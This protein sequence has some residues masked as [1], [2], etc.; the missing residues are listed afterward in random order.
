[1]ATKT[2]NATSVSGKQGWY[3]STSSAIQDS[4]TITIKLPSFTGAEN[5]TISDAKLYI[6]CEAAGASRKKQFA[7]TFKGTNGFSKT[8]TSNGNA[9]NR[10][11][12]LSLNS[13]LK[14]LQEWLASGGTTITS[15]DPQSDQKFGSGPWYSYNYTKITAAKL[16]LTYTY[17]NSSL[18]FNDE[19][20]GIGKNYSL[21][22][23][24]SDET[25]IHDLY[26]RIDESNYSLLNNRTTGTYAI[27]VP[28]AI[29]SNHL[30][31]STSVSGE[32]VL[33]TKKSDETE[34]GT[35]SYPITISADNDNCSPKINSFSFIPPQDNILL[36]D[37]SQLSFIGEAEGSNGSS[38]VSYALSY[39]SSFYETN[40]TGNFTIIAPAG[41]EYI[42]TLTATDTRG[43]STSILS[44]SIYVNAYAI[45][46]I[47]I[48]GFYRCDQYGTRDDVSGT[49]AIISFTKIVSDIK[50]STGENVSNDGTVRVKLNGETY[51][52]A[53]SGS[54]FGKGQLKVD[55][56]YAA[57][58]SIT[59][60]MG[61]TSQPSSLELGSS[62][63]L[64][65]FRRNQNS[66]GIG[67]AADALA[68][69]EDGKVKVAWK[70]ELD[71]ALDVN[72]GGTGAN[73]RE[74]AF[75][76]IV[77]PGGTVLGPL[78]IN[79][80]TIF[81]GDLLVSN[82]NGI[83]FNNTTS[84]GVGGNGNVTFKYS[85]STYVLPNAATNKEYEILST[86][87][88]YQIGDT[89]SIE[90]AYA[91]GWITGSKKDIY[92]V[93]PIGKTFSPDITTG[94]IQTL[95]GNIRCNEEYVSPSGGSTSYVSGGSDFTERVQAVN[96]CLEQ[97]CI[98]V[99]LSIPSAYIVNNST[100][101]FDGTLSL[102]LG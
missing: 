87:N 24:A 93:F 2:L 94:T 98:Y 95:K 39:G 74:N 12:Y 100:L 17:N 79:G 6:T 15:I 37:I 44:R 89:L 8:I 32:Y 96:V 78:N 65:H 91:F 69:G 14:D 9:F 63:Y 20:V 61:Q 5:I 50:T 90:S 35:I 57:T 86:K 4:G 68:D 40:S 66:V 26:I 59:D 75:T 97:N 38:I 31:T 54:I 29:G 1:M 83:Q 82:T 28:T 99:F 73:S 47:K 41:G 23:E 76:N 67:C 55:T 53:A 52:A 22:I 77:S 36:S 30:Y 51:D 80:K 71:K 25:Y 42:F 10:Q 19:N 21:A 62:T 64:I 3:S 101:Q 81:N 16:V 88:Y 102:L 18:S 85:G 60:T 43:Y 46:A 84:I 56:S 92:L 7:L 11:T 27:T 45:P 70:M 49:Y 34:L 58:F 13:K 72:Y 48:D 33:I